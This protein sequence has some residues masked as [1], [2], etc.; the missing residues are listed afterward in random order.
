MNDFD[1][2]LDA[3]LDAAMAQSASQAM[4]LRFRPAN[5]SKAESRRA[6]DQLGQATAGLL[7]VEQELNELL[8]EIT[9]HPDAEQRMTGET[10]GRPAEGLPMFDRVRADA[11][12]LAEL[13]I[14]MH[15][16]ISYARERL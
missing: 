7:K 1:K 5:S 4:P 10:L 16:K 3:D 12:A 13:A 8:Q 11:T 15:A 6:V 14:R 2:T 9:G